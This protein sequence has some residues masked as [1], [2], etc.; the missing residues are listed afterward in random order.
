MVAGPRYRDRTFADRGTVWKALL[1]L[2]LW[3]ACLHS[4]HGGYSSRDYWNISLDDSWYSAN[5]EMNRQLRIYEYVRKGEQI[6][7]WSELVTT[8]HIFLSSPTRNLRRFADRMKEALKNDCRGV[9]WDYLKK[10]SEMIRYEWKHDGCNGEPPQHVLGKLETSEIG[11]HSIQYAMKSKQIPDED[12]AHW[13]SLIVAASLEK[14]L[15]KQPT[16]FAQYVYGLMYEQIVGLPS[17]VFLLT[18]E[19]DADYLQAAVK[20]EASLKLRSKT[21]PPLVIASED[22]KIVAEVVNHALALFENGRLQ[23]VKLIVVGQNEDHAS[24][25][26]EAARLGLHYVFVKY[27]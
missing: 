13:N 12:Y 11:I 16:T 26:L 5:K 19:P 22:P 3:A 24:I 17:N 4:S 18:V 2:T 9:D 25:E 23:G 10:R 1:C 15:F 7:E 20:L 27:E 21:D 8:Q 6:E 14:S